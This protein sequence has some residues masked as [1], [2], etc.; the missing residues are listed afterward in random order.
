MDISI[1]YKKRQ[2]QAINNDSALVKA[3]IKYIGE[4]LSKR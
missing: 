3:Q 4:S 2:I 1:V